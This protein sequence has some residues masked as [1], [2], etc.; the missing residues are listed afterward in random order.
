FP[1]RG[2]FKI[3]DFELSTGFPFGFVRHRRRLAANEADILI[4]PRRSSE[5]PK[6]EITSALGSREPLKTRGAGDDLL[7]LRDYEAADDL[8]RI[9]WKATARTQ[10]I[11]VR[12]FAA[13]ADARV[14]IL[15][16]GFEPSNNGPSL[17]ERLA[18][19]VAIHPAFEAAVSLA[20]AMLTALEA[21]GV[22]FSLAV[23]EKGL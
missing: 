19:K 9:D 12:E 6:V 5:N 13:E 22:E 1:H 21:S 23:G 2:R 4:F 7:F 8:R 15:I 17:R 11:T 18:G 14:R 16:G 10:R 20:A 3:S